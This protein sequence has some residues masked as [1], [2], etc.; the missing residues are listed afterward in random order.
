V[1][2]L[3]QYLHRRFAQAVI[4]N[5]QERRLAQ[6]RQFKIL[7]AAEVMNVK[8]TYHKNND[9]ALAIRPLTASP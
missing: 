9:S 7:Q 5:Q 3:L 8:S 6:D 1:T 4:A 2:D